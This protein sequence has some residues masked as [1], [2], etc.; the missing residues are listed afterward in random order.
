MNYISDYIHFI[1]QINTQ[2]PHLFQVYGLWIYG[3]V[4][5]IIFLECGLIFT[6]FLPGESML[7]ALGAVTAAGNI[8]PHSMVF[9]LV[10]AAILGGFMNY[11]AGRFIGK[12]FLE[13]VKSKHIKRG[14]ARTEE[15]YEKHGVFAVLI[16]RLVPIIRTYVPFFA[17]IV[18]MR[19]SL[20]SILN[21]I[22][23]FVWI[24]VFIYIGFFFGGIPIVQEHFSWFVIAII[25]FSVIPVSIAII[26]EL[27]KKTHD[28]KKL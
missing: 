24:C 10:T 19:F 4:F 2:L 21:I 25:I 5:A 15:F 28:P 18:K 8:A 1:L 12:K 6:P 23:G 3:I 11:A 16:A 14:M 27:R 9:L 13:K 17:G 22:G 20:F 26:K 7:F